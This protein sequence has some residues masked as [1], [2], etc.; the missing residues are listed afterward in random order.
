MSESR[1]RAVEVTIRTFPDDDFVAYATVTG[2]G[3]V[4]DKLLE[5]AETLA[6]VDQAGAVAAWVNDVFIASVSVSGYALVLDRKPKPP[7]S[8]PRYQ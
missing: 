3:D 5:H 2:L 4:V 6:T 1:K 8:R 7:R